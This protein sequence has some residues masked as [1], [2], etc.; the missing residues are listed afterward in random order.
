MPRRT[1]SVFPMEVALVLLLCGSGR[2]QAA[3]NWLGTWKLNVAKSKYSSGPPPKSSTTTYEAWEG[4]VRA[5]TE[6]VGADSATSRVEYAAKF[7][8]K[9]YPSKGS[10]YQVVALKRI[11]DDAFEVS[12][13]HRGR[14]MV[15]VRSV[16]SKDGKTRTQTATGTTFEG[17]PFTNT[18]IFERQK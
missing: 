2:A 10:S 12:F 15:V 3:D 7:D 11:D 1:G 6:S 14:V 9:D 17:T 4:G 16:V 18:L 13:K 8:G 5:V